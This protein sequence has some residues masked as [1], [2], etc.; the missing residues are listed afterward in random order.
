[1]SRLLCISD[2]RWVFSPP[3]STEVPLTRTLKCAWNQFR[4]F[5]ASFFISLRTNE[6]RFALSPSSWS[7]SSSY[8]SLVI[9]AVRLFSGFRRAWSK[10]SARINHQDEHLYK[11]SSQEWLNIEEIVCRIS[12][13]DFALWVKTQVRCLNWTLY[14]W[15]QNDGWMIVLSTGYGSMYRRVNT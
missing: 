9:G 13:T 10:P 12:S 3:N 1:M 8:L 6:V 7:S 5:F 2:E 14:L 4:A 15:Q 11:A